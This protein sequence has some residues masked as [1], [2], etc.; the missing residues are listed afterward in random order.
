LR[1]TPAG[2]K[3]YVLNYR[4]ADGRERRYTIGKHGSPWTCDQAR[5]KAIELR[6]GIAAGED[7][8]EMKAAIRTAVT[9]ADLAELYLAEGPAEKPNKKASSWAADRS[10]IERHIKPLLGRKLVKSLTQA[11]IAKFQA[12]VAAGKTAADVKT[13]WRGRAIVEG[14]KGTAAR[15]LAVLGAMLQFGV[16][17]GLL[18][19]NPAK[20]VKLYKGRK[21]DRFLSAADVTLVADALMA[22]EDE[23]AINTRMA[24]AIRLLMLTGARKGEVLSAKWNYVKWERGCLEL[25]DSKTG[26]KVVPLAEP[27]LEILAEIERTASPYVLPAIKGDGHIVGVQ[28]VW[29]ELRDR[30]TKLARERAIERGEPAETAPDFSTLRLHDFRHSFASF[31]VASGASLYVVGKVLGHRRRVRRR[32]TPTS[33]TIRSRPPLRTRPR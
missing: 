9:V 16:G 22:M 15:S 12:D 18:P 1:V 13:G 20:G 6:R 8:L 10:N 29:E 31:A 14:G 30:A 17:R 25:P 19:T 26:A 21:I 32:S 5:N 2:V 33:T 28:K 24:T 27:A 4:T 23:G 11:D 3:S 7:P